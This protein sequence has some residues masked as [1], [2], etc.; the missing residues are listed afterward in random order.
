MR[1]WIKSIVPKGFLWRLTILNF[2]VVALAMLIT[3][4]AIYETACSLV[5]GIGSPSATRD[6]QFNATL[7]QYFLIFTGLGL[8]ISSIIHFYLTKR[9][10][11]PIR[12]LIEATKSMKRGTYPPPI[13]LRGNDEI[14]ELIT[15]YNELIEQLKQNELYRKKMTDDLSHELRTPIAN[16]KG[17][18]YALQAGDIE[19]N[20]GL[21]GALYDQAEQLAKLIEQFEHLNEWNHRD[22][23]QYFHKEWTAINI[24]LIHC[25]EMF[26]WK[27]QQAGIKIEMNVEAAEIFMYTEGMQQVLNNLFDN[28]IRYYEGTG[29][30]E[31]K[32][33]I[34][35]DY[36]RISISNP[37]MSIQTIDQDKIFDRFYRIESSR[38]RQ[39]G[40]SGLGL[41]IAKEMIEIH[42][43]QIS[44]QSENGVNTFIVDLPNGR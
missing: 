26:K 5:N 27:C 22:A 13:T 33:E 16:I 12:E 18:L 36:Y 21:F 34:V 6:V 32:G 7:F 1:N 35:P 19:G 37:G 3:G 11:H 14:S 31:V 39:T 30:I 28:A 2:I 4:W 15:H 24:M 40:G 29:A 10:I 41:A 44:V 9:L 38:S 42:G 17:Y 8:L 43:G 25:V 23:Q 20:I